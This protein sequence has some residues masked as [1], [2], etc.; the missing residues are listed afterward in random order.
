MQKLGFGT[1][2]FNKKWPLDNNNYNFP[3]KKEIEKY[4]DTIFKFSNDKILIDTASGYNNEFIIG[5]YFKKNPNKI[6]KVFI[7]TKFGELVNNNMNFSYEIMK[8]NF[9]KSKVNLPKI[10]ILY[11]HMIYNSSIINCIN[12]FNNEKI[13]KYINELKKTK[14]IKYF[15]AS[16]SHPE[17]L[18]YLFNNNLFNIDYLQIP[19]WFLDNEYIYKLLKEIYCIGVKIIINSPIRHTEKENIDKKYLKL[20][21][22]NIIECVLTGTRNNLENTFEYYIYDAKS[23]FQNLFNIT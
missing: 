10:D 6:N 23:L 13:I 12:F 21:N 9:N 14:Q 15:G 16:I 4:L 20:F 7:A 1:I 3:D 18:K 17:V 2:W 8:K 19:A 11:V 22:N 5:D